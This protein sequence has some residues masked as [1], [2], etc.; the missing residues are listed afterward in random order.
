ML[1]PR[2]H[3]SPA[4]GAGATAREGKGAGRVDGHHSDGRLMGAIAASQP[5]D[6]GALA[7]AGRAGDADAHRGAA[8]GEAAG[9][10]PPCRGRVI[11][12]QRN[13]PRQ[14][15]YISLEQTPDQLHHV[16]AVAL[17]PSR[18]Y[19]SQIEIA[20]GSGP[21]FSAAPTALISSWGL[22]PALPGWAY[23]WR[24]ALRASHPSLFSISF[25]TC[26]RQA[27]CS[28]ARRDRRDDKRKGGDSMRD[29]IVAE[30]R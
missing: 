5:I 8:I 12:H 6:Q 26:H 21:R 16:A 17:H 14:R 1:S 23:V 19:D 18:S 29:R 10:N 15:A 22:I 7:R 4:A 24:P 9:K 30:G 20:D 2:S 11:L 13:R 28:T 3:G 27:S 25:S